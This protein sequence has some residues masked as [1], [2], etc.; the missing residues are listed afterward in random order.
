M[1]S[2]GLF[3]PPAQRGKA[4]M[5][6]TPGSTRG[7]H[8]WTAVGCYFPDRIPTGPGRSRTLTHSAFLRPSQ[9]HATPVALDLDEHRLSTATHSVTGEDVQC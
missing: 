2:G 3:E 9:R 1:F 8:S 7:A 5:G 6:P 4:A